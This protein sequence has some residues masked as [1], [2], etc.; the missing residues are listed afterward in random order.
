MYSN[1]YP[2]ATAINVKFIVSMQTVL[3]QWT[4]HVAIGLKFTI[5]V[6]T[7]VNHIVNSFIVGY[8]KVKAIFSVKDGLLTTDWVY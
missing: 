3:R 4:K 1:I 5:V 2:T 6:H 8:F 7:A